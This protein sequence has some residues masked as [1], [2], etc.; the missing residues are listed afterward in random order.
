MWAHLTLSDNAQILCERF[1]T[2]R[3][4]WVD[5]ILSPSLL[6]AT[7]VV[8]NYTYIIALI[9]IPLMLVVN[10]WTPCLIFKVQRL[11]IY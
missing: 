11:D 6:T 7:H 9:A 2:S 4:G 10:M 8:Q 1:R 5:T 3:E